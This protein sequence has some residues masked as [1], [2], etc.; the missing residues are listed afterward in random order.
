MQ[1]QEM[2]G[3]GDALTPDGDIRTLPTMHLDGF[4]IARIALN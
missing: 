2:P 4:F 3:L 1:P